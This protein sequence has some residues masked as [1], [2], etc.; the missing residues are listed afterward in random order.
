MLRAEAVRYDILSFADGGH[1]RVN[2]RACALVDLQA[3]YLRLRLGRLHAPGHGGFAAVE[4]GVAGGELPHQ[5]PEP[6]LEAARALQPG[7]R[8]LRGPGGQHRR[9]RRQRLQR[10]RRQPRGGARVVDQGSPHA[11]DGGDAR[12]E[13][14]GAAARASCWSWGGWRRCCTS[15]S[16]GQ[17]PSPS[18]PCAEG[19][20]GALAAAGAV[21]PAGRLRHRAGRLPSSRA[22]NGLGK[23]QR[24]NRD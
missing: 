23:K 2:P 20:G 15:R 22:H 24:Y 12:L 4:R 17:R 16:S 19:S 1:G 3:G 10:L 9:D 18:C 6:G 11:S 8:R 13:P 7:H 21:Q 5:V 14:G